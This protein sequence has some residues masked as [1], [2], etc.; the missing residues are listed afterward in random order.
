MT[1]YAPR[2]SVLYVP[3][4]NARALAKA[5][6][7]SCDVVIL[8]LEDSVAPADKDSARDFACLSVPAF[9]GREVVLRVNGLGTPWYADDLA[10]ARAAQ[11][12]AVLVPKVSSAADVAQVV[13][14]L[15]DDDL[16]VW[17]MLETP[18]SI[19]RAAEIAASPRVQV[20]VMGTNDLSAELR[21]T[22]RLAL[23]TSLGL[24]VLAARTAGIDILDGVFNAVD[25]PV[26]L[27]AE[28]EEGRALGFDGKTL[29]HPGQIAAANA[30]FAPSAEAVAAAEGIVASWGDGRSGVV[31]HEGRIVEQL[32]VD[33]AR[34]TLSIAAA[35]AAR[36]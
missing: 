34:R 25:D 21:G 23:F 18:S 32:H 11:P 30:A 16:P 24:G 27:R 28:C 9:E 20:L 17:V 7:L 6:W 19:L 15:G 3:A 8:D 35:I 22:S 12:N 10:A 5:P 31:L 26:G 1:D 2:R 29:I 14:D 33:A 36:S 4:S 13:A